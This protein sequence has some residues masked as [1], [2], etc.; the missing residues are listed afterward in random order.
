MV[1]VMQ[2][3]YPPDIVLIDEPYRKLRTEGD[4]WLYIYNH[5]NAGKETSDWIAMY[6]PDFS[7][8]ITTIA[9]STVGVGTASVAEI[10]VS[11]YKGEWDEGIQVFSETKPLQS[12]IVRFDVGNIAL[13]D[14]SIVIS[15]RLRASAGEAYWHI[16]AP[17]VYYEPSEVPPELTITDVYLDKTTISE[18]ESVTVYADVSNAAST[19]RT[20]SLQVSVDGHVIDT[21]TIT[22]PARSTKTF[23]YTITAL[24]VG[25]HEIC[26]DL[27]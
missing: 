16:S 12:P 22:V 27:V 13:N 9:F 15:V 17:I 20:A 1:E 24:T 14:F 10:T 11:L 3:L 6:V 2:V 8:R 25:M 18:G 19:D 5:I 21:V 4:K 23:S 7:G 26:V